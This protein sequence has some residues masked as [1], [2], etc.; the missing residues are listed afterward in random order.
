MKQEEAERISA[1]IG[2]VPVLDLATA[3]YRPKDTVMNTINGC[4]QAMLTQPNNI[5]WAEGDGIAPQII[6]GFEANPGTQVDHF[7]DSGHPDA[8]PTKPLG[9]Q[10]LVQRCGLGW[11]Q[12]RGR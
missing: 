6:Q 12:P 1:M 9:Q 5:V 7:F 3:L 10:V 8:A 2:P 11:L 4:H